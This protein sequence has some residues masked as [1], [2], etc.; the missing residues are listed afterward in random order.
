MRSACHGCLCC[1]KTGGGF[2]LRTPSGLETKCLSCAIR[3]LPLVRR[4]VAVSAVM[5]SVLTA[6]NQ[7]D[8]LITGSWSRALLWKLPLTYAVPFIVATWGALANSRDPR[9]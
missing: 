1:E 4:S 5:G 3:H 8:A 9:R 7:G 2:R 6:I